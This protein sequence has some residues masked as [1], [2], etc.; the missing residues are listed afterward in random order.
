M[1]GKA[2]WQNA[3]DDGLIYLVIICY[4]ATMGALL[5]G[6]GINVF[7][8]GSYLANLIL[9][10]A[11]LIVIAA[12][13][14]I[15]ALARH[16]LGARGGAW[17]VADRFA[18]VFPFLLALAAFNMTFS[19]A[20]SAIPLFN[21]YRHDR[22]FTDMDVVLHGGHAWE[23]LQP[24]L[25]YPLITFLINAVYH[26]WILLLYIG[27]PL[28]CLWIERPDIR[29]Q[30]LVAY[31]LCWIVLGTVLAIALASV[32]PCFMEA[33]FGDRSFRP[34]MDYLAFADT[35][36]P[37]WVLDV[38]REL[39]AWHQQKSHELGRGI[40]AMPSMHVSLA[41]LFAIV[42]WRHSP[43][44]GLAAT[45]FLLLILLGSVHLGYHYAVDG[46][47]SILVTPMLWGLAG[48]IQAR[49]ARNDIKGAVA[50]SA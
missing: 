11:G 14:L 31:L 18:G 7:R 25:G 45:I 26:S 20:K 10:A 47:L 40:S 34:L 37:I 38:Q 3:R 39:I 43:A 22:L 30:F 29:R 5:W 50:A 28:V 19:A 21:D 33:F 16:W 24:L 35:R 44:V 36:Y 32:G 23:L 15:L 49:V 12:V 17:R 4:L 8:P 48:A 2:L 9:Y 41:C 46:Y 42:G 1:F 27:M 13:A 6:H